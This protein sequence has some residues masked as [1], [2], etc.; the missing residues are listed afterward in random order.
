MTVASDI[1]FHRDNKHK[2]NNLLGEVSNDED[3]DEVEGGNEAEEG[4]EDNEEAEEET[5]DDN[6]ET[7]DVDED[8]EEEARKEASRQN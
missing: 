7:E 4:N 6:K 1:Q 3:E 8:D 5:E 2:N